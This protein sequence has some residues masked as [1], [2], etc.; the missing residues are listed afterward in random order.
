MHVIVCEKCRRIRLALMSLLIVFAAL[1]GYHWGNLFESGF[2][3]QDHDVV[4]LAVAFTLL[5]AAVALG[6]EMA[7]TRTEM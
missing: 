7:V 3:V 1:A 6:V 2:H 4:I 5:A